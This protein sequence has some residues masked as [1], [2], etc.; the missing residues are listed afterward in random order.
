MPFQSEKQRRYL[1]ANE[2]EIARDWSD[3][4]GH[5]ARGA[6]GG[7][8]RV[9]FYA[10][11][12]VES[13]G[14]QPDFSNYQAMITDKQMQNIDETWPYFEGGGMSLQE[15]YEGAK[16]WDDEGSK[17]FWGMGKR[18]AEPM[19][20][21]EFQK[22][23]INRG[24]LNLPGKSIQ[25]FKKLKNIGNQATDEFA[26]IEGYTARKPP[27]YDTMSDAHTGDVP[28]MNQAYEE[29]NPTLDEEG[30]AQLIKQAEEEGEDYPVGK[31][32]SPFKRWSKQFWANP[33]Q[34]VMQGINMAFNP[35]GN[36]GRAAAGYA[37]Q[38]G[39]NL[40]QGLTNL[41][42]G[43]ATQGGYNQ[44]RDQR[45][46]AKR[47]RQRTSD[48]TQANI[49]ALNAARQQKFQEETR[50]L[51]EAQWQQQAPQVQQNIQ[52]GGERP[53]TGMN[54]P[55]GGWG[56]SPTGGNVAGTPFRHGGLAS[57]WT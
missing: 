45:M 25:D 31:Q 1:W 26:D 53:D 29:F 49:Q 36:I 46:L 35:F 6:D 50:R 52:R 37:L 39:Q 23:M 10:G 15:M 51:Q 27:R 11:E 32:M 14:T 17:G 40:R 42:G 54:A 19:S 48:K 5:K 44:A 33:G 13:I 24:Y 41:R 34:R 8:M 28:I 18:E 55:G 4:Y 21:Q 12:E 56:Q 3:T 16:G 47:I 2:P 20:M 30:I 38:G 22:E 9:P 57:L 7:V 43:Y